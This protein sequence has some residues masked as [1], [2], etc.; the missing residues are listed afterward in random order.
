MDEAAL[1]TIAVLFIFLAM[2]LGILGQATAS[3]IKNLD[4]RLHHLETEKKTE[5]ATKKS[6]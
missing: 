2:L 1:K 3:A 6:V 5:G 4:R